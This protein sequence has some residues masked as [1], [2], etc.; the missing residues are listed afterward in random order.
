MIALLFSGGLDST[1]LAHEALDAAQLGVLVFV[2]YG[3]PAESA[4]A[5]A[6]AEWRRRY[7]RHIPLLDVGLPI[8]AVPM[9][10]G[11][12]VPGPRI[13]PGRNLLL[14][15]FAV[16][17]AARYKCTRVWYGAQAGDSPQYADCTPEFVSSFARLA[18][19]WGVQVEAPLLACTKRQV[20]ERA[21][22]CGVDFELA[23]SCYEPR[24]GKPCTTCN[25]CRARL[26]A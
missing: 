6:V 7:A 3:Q 5:H 12:G 25:A 22:A 4:E 15:S 23:W 16:A 14:L 24:D 10:L 18:S 26:E 17:L 19:P 20:K 11:V 9:Q 13:L 2:R 1:V 21:L 8:G